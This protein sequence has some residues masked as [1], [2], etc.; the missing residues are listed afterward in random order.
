[1]SSINIFKVR[2]H[3]EAQRVVMYQ[4]QEILEGE[5]IDINQINAFPNVE[6]FHQKPVMPSGQDRDD[7]NNPQD[8]I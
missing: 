7:L 4:G 1:M 6:G 8:F 2:V 5:M 3:P